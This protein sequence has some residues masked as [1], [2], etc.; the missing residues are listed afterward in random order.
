MASLKR[1][2]QKKEAA[3]GLR[4]KSVTKSSQP[5]PYTPEGDNIL[6]VGGKILRFTDPQERDGRVVRSI[7]LKCVY[8]VAKR[9]SELWINVYDSLGE[10]LAQRSIGDRVCLGGYIRSSDEMDPTT[11]RHW[12]LYVNRILREG[13]VNLSGSGFARNRVEVRGLLEHREM[14]TAHNGNPKCDF[15]LRCK[16]PSGRSDLVEMTAYDMAFTI[17]EWPIK[18]ELWLAAEVLSYPGKFTVMSIVPH[19]RLSDE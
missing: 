6:E 11:R 2:R 17:N 3:R 19:G 5:V 8:D 16:G 15:G 1:R 12:E 9:P 14:G 13:A 10:Y 7:K 4:S 18:R